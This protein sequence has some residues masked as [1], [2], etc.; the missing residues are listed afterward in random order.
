MK[1]VF[2]ILVMVI[3]LGAAC[4]PPEPTAAPT[5][6]PAETLALP[7]YP[8]LTDDQAAYVVQSIRE[9]FR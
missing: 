6:S 8:E 1:K 9:F 3:L 2:A 4:N 7:V 5:A